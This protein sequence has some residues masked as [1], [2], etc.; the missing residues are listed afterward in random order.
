MKKYLVLLLV[1]FCVSPAVAD[2][3]DIYGIST[4]DVKPNVL[5]IFDNSNS[6][7][8][9][10]IPGDVYDP[11]TA[12]T[13]DYDSNTVYWWQY[14]QGTCRRYR[15]GRCVKYNYSWNLVPYFSNLTNSN[16]NWTCTT[17]KTGLL[18]DGYWT[19]SLT[20]SGSNVN[21]GGNNNDYWI[22]NFLNFDNQSSDTEIRMVVAKRV[23]AKLIDDNIDNVNFGVMKFNP[24]E[25]RPNRVD[26]GRIVEE[27]GASRTDLIGNYTSSTVF[28]DSNQSS[29][30]GAIGGLES[31]TGTPL[32][33]SLAEAGL[34]F[35]GKRG[36]FNNTTYTSPIEYRCQK[37]YIILVTDGSPTVDGEK[38][39]T[40]KYLNN[41]TIPSLGHDGQGV[42]GIY[43]KNDLDDNLPSYLDD[44]SYFL[45]NE[46][47]RPDLGSAGDFEYQT[48]T[49]YT[50]GMLGTTSDEGSLD[51][52]EEVAA[53]GN[54]RN[55][56]ATSA[57][58]LGAALSS[59]ISTIGESNEQFA[60]TAVP[61]NSDDGFTSG[62][63]VYFGLFQPL[64]NNNWAGNLKKYALDGGVI[65]DQ[66][67]HEAIT[68]SAAFA[69]NAISYWSTGIDGNKVTAGGAGGVLSATIQNG[70]LARTI[71]TYTGTQNSLSHDSNLFIATN[72]TLTS[73]TY[74]GLTT[75][76]INAVRHE[77]DSDNWPLG[78]IIHSEPLVIHY[79]SGSVIYI[80]ANDGMLHCFDDTTGSEKWGFIPQDLLSSLSVLESPTQL[81]YFVD[82]SPT[83]YSYDDAGTTK[84]ILLF[85]ERR[86]GYSYTALDVSD[87]DAPSFKYAIN[88]DFLTAAGSSEVLGQ[89]W[90]KPQ[91]CSML[92]SSNSA[93]DVFL[94]PG[95]Y[96]TNE[97]KLTIA[98]PDTVG[99]AVFAVD[100][101]T[102]TLLSNF[103]FNFDNFSNMTHSIVSVS[104]F[105]NP[106]SRTTTRV[107]A[108]DLGG[109]MFAFRDDQYGGAEDGVWQ[110]KV[111]LF[112]SPGKKIFYAPNI[113]NEYYVVNYPYIGERSDPPQTKT[114][115]GDFVFY[116]TGDRAHPTRTDI[117]N[118]FY[119]I[120]NSWQ[121]E[122]SAGTA[123]ETP[124]IVK[125]FVDTSDGELKEVETTTAISDSDLFLLDVTDDLLQ[126]VEEDQ[127]TRTLYTNYI[128]TALNNANNRGWYL[129]LEGAGEK[130]V[131]QPTIF[132]GVVYFVT[133]VPDNS[134]GVSDDPCANPGSSGVSYLYALDYKDGGAVIDF[135]EDDEIKKE[136]RKLTL[137]SS[138]ISPEPKIVTPDDG[139]PYLIVGKQ[140]IELPPLKGVD[141]FYW[142]QL[143]D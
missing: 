20:K 54:G 28:T 1:L 22:G 121:W 94:L 95:G 75:D 80:G 10:D 135:N 17:A 21:C 140:K 127:A 106:D 115:K 82:G 89:S 105:E 71:Y 68:G 37:N 120:K 63:Y 18:T 5:I 3:T 6:M 4:I 96:D 136:D 9:K 102:G 30:Y 66:N 35:A 23:I 139:D 118:E 108:G 50:V 78:A 131:S 61:V 44:V 7:S 47:L 109:N 126:N 133:Y 111:K 86:G 100:S 84:R 91:R 117:V 59:I 143:N 36:W 29:T 14:E 70:S 34:Y 57:A 107:Y 46:D 122:D 129:R 69:D 32:A 26:G 85:G 81:Y 24:I 97:D 2:D 110:Q 119:A 77:D 67:N 33:E 90:S 104:G 25:S 73:G 134:T 43:G 39:G 16:T 49:T 124:T 65:K 123:T 88:S 130:V 112:A 51:F 13:G 103:N 87:P 116:G 60:S 15:W 72:S 99:R 83:V 93:T 8:D 76:V 48:V 31:E 58:N 40:T 62:D 12:Y 56:P 45:A 137:N 125:A 79:D 113:T 19:G 114:I 52:L 74:S 128:N 55:Y 41:K 11:E 98:T 138:G 38:I 101:K 64:S 42:I 132:G 142:R 92:N 53:N 141:L 27:C